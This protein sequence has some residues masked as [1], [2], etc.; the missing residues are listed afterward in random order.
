VFRVARF[1]SACDELL[2]RDRR[3]AAF[4]IDNVFNA[5]VFNVDGVPLSVDLTRHLDGSPSA[6][7]KSPRSNLDDFARQLHPSSSRP[8]DHEF[9]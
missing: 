1:A 7:A 3:A 6:E 9:D 2:C 4:G 8:V 5:N